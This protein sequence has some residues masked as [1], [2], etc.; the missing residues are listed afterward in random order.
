[1]LLWLWRRP[2]ATALI[3][4]LAWETPYAVNSALKDERIEKERKGKERKERETGKRVCVWGQ[5]FDV[6]D[7]RQIY[8]S[9]WVL[10]CTF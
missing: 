5:N 3:G 10:V 8:L 6:E 2:L 7:E 9:C 4:P 1:M